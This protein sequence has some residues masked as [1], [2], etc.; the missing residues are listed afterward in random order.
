MRGFVLAVCLFVSSLPLH[1]QISL[2]YNGKQYLVS[3]TSVVKDSAQKVY[4][5]NDWLNMISSGEFDI[6]PEEPG[7]KQ[8]S[9]KLV[10][11]GKEEQANRL[12][13]A[14]KPIESNAFRGKKKIEMFEA[15]DI[16]DALVNIKSLKGKIVVLNFWFIRCPPCRLERP[17]LNQLVDEYAGDSNIVFIAVSLDPRPQLETY[18]KDSPFKYQVIA[19]GMNIAK[20]NKVDQYPTHVILDQEGKI[21]FNTISYNAVTGYWLRKTI[22]ELKKQ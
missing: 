5:Y 11:L 19:D 2:H 17:Y 14:P 3:Q 6:M 10:R 8:S 4:A 15:H 13:A 18:L 16:K 1:A 22:N 21:A 7:N 9:F 12:A 20:K